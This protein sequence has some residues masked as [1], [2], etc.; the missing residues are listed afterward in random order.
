MT[1]RITI[2]PGMTIRLVRN[3]DGG[4]RRALFGSVLAV[5]PVL[6][7]NLGTNGEPTLSVAMLDPR[8]IDIVQAGRADWHTAME[9][10]TGV[11][12]ASHPEVLAGRTS[13]YYVDALPID[14]GEIELD[15]LNITDLSKPAYEIRETE[16]GKEATLHENGAL[17][18]VKV[19]DRYEVR[20]LDG[21]KV[22]EFDN[23]QIASSYIDAQQ[24]PVLVRNLS[25]LVPDSQHTQAE[26]Y[27]KAKNTVNAVQAAEDDAARQDEARE[28]LKKTS[29]DER[30]AGAWTENNDG[31]SYTLPQSGATATPLVPAGGETA[32]AS[33][34]ATEPVETE[35]GKETGIGTEPVNELLVYPKDEKFYFGYKATDGHIDVAGPFDTYSEAREAKEAKE[36]EVTL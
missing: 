32:P 34:A 18:A 22:Q 7:E 15:A 33:P 35:P 20:D 4:K 14:G 28:A 16:P 10:V 36:K 17:H 11:R 19:G 30:G 24:G 1:P 25:P 23:L 26:S 9:R 8:A 27:Y 21:N 5:A 13:L 6:P 2:V 29:G 31:K 3:L 12:H